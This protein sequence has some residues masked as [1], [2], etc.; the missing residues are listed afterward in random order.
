M[1]T[2]LAAFG[3]L[4]LLT[5]TVWSNGPE[6]AAPHGRTFFHPAPGALSAYGTSVAAM[7]DLD[8]DGYG[9]AVISDPFDGAGVVFLH[10]GAAGGF[11]TTPAGAARGLVDGEQFGMS[12]GRVGD[13]DGDGIADLAV[14]APFSSGAAG[15]KETGRLYL[16]SGATLLSGGTPTPLLV[17]YGDAR[18]DR[19]GYNLAAGR[20]A[21]GDGVPDLIVSALSRQDGRGWVYLVDGTARGVGAISTF[22]VASVIGEAPA[23]EIG[24][25]AL[26]MLPDL[27]GDGRAEWV[28]GAPEF[29]DDEGRVY[30]LASLPVAQNVTT[31]ALRTWDAG[32]PDDGMGFSVAHVTLQ[33]GRHVLAV[34]A[35]HAGSG[36]GRVYLADPL[37]PSGPIDQFALSRLEGFDGGSSGTRLT[38]GDFDADGDQD[39]VVAAPF[40]K[41]GSFT[42]GKIGLLPGPL[43]ESPVQFIAEEGAR[44]RGDVNSGR[45]GHSVAFL[46]NPD[47]THPA[48]MLVGEPRGKRAHLLTNLPPAAVANPVTVPCTG[49]FTNVTVGS[50]GTT[51]PDGYA[52]IFRFTWTDPADPLGQVIGHG[53]QL[54]LS[55]PPGQRTFNLKVDDVYLATDA[56]QS[57]TV[58]V[59]DAFPPTLALDRPKRSTVYLEDEPIL[60]VDLPVVSW[61]THVGNVTVKARAEDR[62]SDVDRVEF[63]LDDVLAHTDREAPYTFEYDPHTIYPAAEHLFARAW[64][65]QGNGPASEC[66]HLVNTGWAS[67]HHL[68]I[69]GEGPPEDAP[70]TLVPDPL[71]HVVAAHPRCNDA[72]D[73]LL[74]DFVH[75]LPIASR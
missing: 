4:L 1:R 17:A 3:V 51:D 2:L 71:G 63:W 23:D 36:S 43:G 31:A 75:P 33:D 49:R 48:G 39:L 72:L 64:D 61:A 29:D 40:A 7:G 24:E 41:T 11:G 28:V 67:L 54:N 9:D 20:D 13:I 53:P 34:G 19:L 65:T 12:V 44:I 37:G 14:G 74:P 56:N 66:I 5:P 69:L 25:H 15:A 35:F 46:E 16:F 22:A 55:L 68:P 58:R 32:A 8:G 27:T 10:R 70:S 60:S 57:G 62:C 73:A 30:L 38:A 6:S 47:A 45:F 26:V 42:Y 52:D 21:T 18:L 59:V 50:D